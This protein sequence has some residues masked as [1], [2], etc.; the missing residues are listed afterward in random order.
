MKIQDLR[1]QVKE[2]SSGAAVGG[3]SIAGATGGLGNVAPT[4]KKKTK[5]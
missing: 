1:R 5:R 4:E 3:G 2:M